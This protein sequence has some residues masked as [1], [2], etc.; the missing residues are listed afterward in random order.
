[1]RTRTLPPCLWTCLVVGLT[2][3]VA[4]GQGAPVNEPGPAASAEPASQP[5]SP[6]PDPSA[7]RDDDGFCRANWFAMGRCR[8]R[9]WAGPKIMLGVDLGLAVMTET[10][11]FGFNKGVGS[12][13]EGGPGWGLRAGVDFFPWL[14]LEARYVGVYDSAR[15]SV[16]PAGSV[17]FLTTAGEAVVRLTAPIPFVHPY[18]FGGIG[19][20][21]VSLVGSSSARAGSVLH[22]SSQSG[23]PVGFG[24]D[25]PLTW[26]LS[27]DLEAGYHWQINEDY[28]AV[29]TNGI[30]GGDLST[31][32]A[33]LRARL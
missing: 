32:S 8:N 22:S 7:G 28:S 11:P 4:F 33:V 12:A 6:T 25:V 26:Y 16:S 13:T 30:D 2:V 29:T 20:Y 27:V 3:R 15:A 18:V 14:G 1:M 21:D 9:P 19:Y 31:V 17:G 10:G 24:V 23:I 5:N